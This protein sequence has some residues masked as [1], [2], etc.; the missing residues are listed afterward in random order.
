MRCKPQFITS[1]SGVTTWRTPNKKGA[2]HFFFFFSLTYNSIRARHLDKWKPPPIRA[3]LIQT[4]LLFFLLNEPKIKFGQ[5]L[6][7]NFNYLIIKYKL[8][9][10][11]KKFI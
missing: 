4:C 3:G 2:K 8:I 11:K 1:S 10:L 6:N 7:F 9:Q 5:M